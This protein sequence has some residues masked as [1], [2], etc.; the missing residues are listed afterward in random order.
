MSTTIDRVHYYER[1]YLRSFDLTAEQLYHIEM[2]RRLNLAL[3]LWGIVDGLDLRPSAAVPGLPQEFHISRGMAIDAFGREIVVPIDYRLTEADL[4]R[5]RIRFA[6][7]YFVS[8][9]YARELATPPQGGFRVCDVKEQF[10]RLREF[11]E[12]LITEN[13]PTPQAATLPTAS[14]PLSDDPVAQPWPVVLGTIT[15]A[16]QGGKLIIQTATAEQRIYAGIR[17]QRVVTPSS[18]VTSNAAQ[19]AL[20]FTVASTV[21]AEQNLFIGSDVPITNTTAKQ[22]PADPTKATPPGKGVLKVEDDMFVQGDFYAKIAGEW[23]TMKEYLQSFIPDVKVGRIPAVIPTP[24][25]SA[26][27]NGTTENDIT[28]ELETRVKDPQ[29]QLLTV[30]I[31]SIDFQS[32]NQRTEW[33]ANSDQT[34]LPKLRVD[35][36]PGAVKLTS[37]KFRFTIHWEIEP[38]SAQPGAPPPAAQI[39]IRRFEL[40]YVAV[41][42]PA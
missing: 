10:T 25:V 22:P 18:S 8:V 12:V 21:L 41:F 35:V 38:T 30:A 19:T 29:E 6:K 5:N 1:Q 15:T 3:H 36:V 20:P 39:P 37:T 4:D 2:R 28:L 26:S 24:L 40:S 11:Y 23:L 33:D 13:N 14:D 32:E 42:N 27:T 7:T 17:A 34:A 16:L 9:A 31:A